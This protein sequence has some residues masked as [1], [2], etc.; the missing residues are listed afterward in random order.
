MD[1]EG[2]MIIFPGIGDGRLAAS[3]ERGEEL[4]CSLKNARIY[5]KSRAMA[6]TNLPPYR[7]NGYRSIILACL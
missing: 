1:S 6:M 4:F 5:E 2:G 7:S 3:D